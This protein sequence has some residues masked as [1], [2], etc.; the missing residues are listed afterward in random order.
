[1]DHR[2]RKSRYAIVTHHAVLDTEALPPGTST[3][4]AE[5]IALMRALHLGAKSKVIIYT[6]SEYAFSV[7]HAYG[8]IK[9]ERSSNFRKKKLNM[10]KRYWPY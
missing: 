1:M 6:D 7:L 8:Y 10:Q 3:Q 2:L 9:R 5:L 4:K